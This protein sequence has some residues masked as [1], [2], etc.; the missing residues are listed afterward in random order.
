VRFMPPLSVTETEV[1]EAVALLRLSLD[2]ALR[3]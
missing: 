2:E 1:D 3:G